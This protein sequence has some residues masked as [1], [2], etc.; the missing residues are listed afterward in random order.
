MYLLQVLHNVFKRVTYVLYVPKENIYIHKYSTMQA[1]HRL[2]QCE[3]EGL[4]EQNIP[5]INYKWTS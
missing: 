1:L 4:F 2:S 3:E 5:I